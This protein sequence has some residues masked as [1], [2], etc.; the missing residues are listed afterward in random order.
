MK[1]IITVFLLLFVMCVF[2]QDAT[3]PT[4]TDPWE[5]FDRI[6][7]D[8]ENKVSQLQ[9]INEQD[10]KT[11]SLLI[12]DISDAKEL[13]VEKDLEIREKDDKLIIKEYQL[14]KLRK[15]L[16]W[17]G[18]ALAILILLRLVR[19]FLNWFP[20]TRPWCQLFFSTKLGKLLDIFVV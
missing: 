19:A 3:P 7:T 4:I 16:F 18:F 12:E 20:K 9:L 14:E 15:K 11:I 6:V 13:L 10:S 17:V 2:A 1:K 5:Q 8:I